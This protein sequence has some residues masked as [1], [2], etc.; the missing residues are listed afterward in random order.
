MFTGW[1]RL[2]CGDGYTLVVCY[3]AV[4]SAASPENVRCCFVDARRH[5]ACLN[6]T[7]SLTAKPTVGCGAHECLQRGLWP[8]HIPLLAGCISFL[9][10]KLLLDTQFLGASF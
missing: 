4:G 10:Q 7:A 8:P 6:L 2:P 5:Q 3:Q 9:N 1:T